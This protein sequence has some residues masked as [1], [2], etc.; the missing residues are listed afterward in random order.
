MQRNHKQAICLVSM[1][2]LCL[3]LTH[4]VAAQSVQATED[5][6]THAGFTPVI[7][8][9]AGYIHNVNGGITSLE[10]QIN[11][12][13]LVPFGSHVLL[14]SRTDFTG[15]FQREDQTTGP[16]KGKV[17]KTVD[18]A[19]IDWLA[20]THVIAS[21]GKYLLP[22]GLYNERLVPV[23]IR[24]LQDP[25]ITAAIGTRTSGAGDGIMLRGIVVQ[26][27]SYSIQYSSYFSARSDINQLQAARTAGGDASIYFTRLRLEA[28]TSYQRFLQQHN[29][30]SAATYVTWQPRTV[31]IDIKAEGDYSYNGRG[32][33]IE[34]AYLFQQM[35]I[36][37]FFRRTQVVGRMQQFFP[38]NG[39]GNS[40]PHVDTNRFDFGLN[41][42]F[43]DD[44]RI[45]SSYGRS[46]S[47]QGNANVWNVGLT[48]R[49]IFP[50]WPARK[51]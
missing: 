37:K 28:G 18:F 26:N 51:K 15:F 46:F 36:P 21:A 9:G 24:N 4:C 6:E 13:L 14:E 2:G 33:W 31:P 16:F 27:P 40:L 32:Y 43:R 3:A 48:Y 12:L 49:F 39:G 30:N 44:L 42:Y 41:Y 45:V 23:W 19:Q 50:L 7:S 1:L 34:A 22:F 20:N 47:S 29:I 8:G 11:P 35:P 17:F 10:P 25:P 38:L 5:L